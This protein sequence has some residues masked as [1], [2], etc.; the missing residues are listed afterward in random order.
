MVC[1]QIWYYWGKLRLTHFFSLAYDGVIIDVPL[2]MTKTLQH[3][4]ILTFIFQWEYLNNFFSSINF[5]FPTHRPQFSTQHDGTGLKICRKQNSTPTESPFLTFWPS[6][7]AIYPKVVKG[8]KI[9]IFWHYDNILH[10]YWKMR[11]K[12]KNLSFSW[13]RF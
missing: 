8:V 7:L 11:K 6:F 9:S 12:C 2:A 4:I 1:F 13:R 10:Y 5:V 3:L